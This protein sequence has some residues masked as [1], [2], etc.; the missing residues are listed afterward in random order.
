MRS[1]AI[2]RLFFRQIQNL[3]CRI[4][5]QHN[6]FCSDFPEVSTLRQGLKIPS[7]RRN[8]S[9]HES[10]NVKATERQGSLP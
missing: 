1:T 6:S 9:V 7:S 5:D 8:Q 10:E 2:D 4:P 3:P